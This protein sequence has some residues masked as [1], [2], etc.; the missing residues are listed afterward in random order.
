MKTY[1]FVYLKL[2]VVLKMAMEP[3]IVVSR[4]SRKIA[5]YEFVHQNVVSLCI[6]PDSVPL[7]LPERIPF[8]LILISFI[9][10]ATVHCL[11][12]TG[13]NRNAIGDATSLR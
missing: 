12:F 10:T 13:G 9:S 8:F 1:I 7:H 2:L 3:P 6:L 4:I 11:I 5:F